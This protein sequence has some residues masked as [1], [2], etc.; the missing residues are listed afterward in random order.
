MQVRG[1]Q[2]AGEGKNPNWINQMRPTA[3]NF[4]IAAS[5]RGN[6]HIVHFEDPRFAY[7]I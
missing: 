4:A 5:I 7:D 1:I 3:K 6:K 2:N